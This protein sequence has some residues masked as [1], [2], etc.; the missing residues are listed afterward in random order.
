MGQFNC[1]VFKY[2]VSYIYHDSDWNQML[3]QNN[4][5]QLK[6]VQG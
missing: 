1:T 5:Q 4:C 2:V 3:T 6:I